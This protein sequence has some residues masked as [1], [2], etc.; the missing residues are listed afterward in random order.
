MLPCP[1]PLAIGRAH[2]SN[3]GRIVTPYPPNHGGSQAAA[4]AAAHPIPHPKWARGVGPPPANAAGHWA[5]SGA[6]AVTYHGSIW[7]GLGL[8][9]V[10]GV[11]GYLGAILP[12]IG[13]QVLV[14]SAIG[15]V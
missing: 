8:L 10:L 6:M 13:W 11:L 3:Y 5:T 1:R 12:R 15:N 7:E 14:T 9:Q 4:E 2:L